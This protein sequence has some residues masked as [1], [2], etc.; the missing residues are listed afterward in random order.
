[1]SS[2]PIY[3]SQNMHVPTCDHPYND[4][5]KYNSSPT[6]NPIFESIFFNK[7]L[8][9]EAIFGGSELFYNSAI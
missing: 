8:L 2:Y 1:M 9:L 4:A 5:G 6:V 3:T 7:N